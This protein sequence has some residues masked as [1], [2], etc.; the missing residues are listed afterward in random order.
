MTQSVLRLDCGQNGS[1]FESRRPNL[2]LF[3]VYR[4]SFP[5]VERPGRDSDH[6]SP[7]SFDVCMSRGSKYTP[8]NSL[9]VNVFW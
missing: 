3:S 2:L 1:L 8:Y 7:S 4:S 5:V 9:I 6:S